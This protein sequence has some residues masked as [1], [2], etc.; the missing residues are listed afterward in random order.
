M[1]EAIDE[2]EIARYDLE[3]AQWGELRRRIEGERLGPC[4]TIDYWADQDWEA[5]DLYEHF[6][7]VIAD[8]AKP[9]YYPTFI[10]SPSDDPKGNPVEQAPPKVLRYYGALAPRHAG[11]EWVGG[12][13]VSSAPH[14]ADAGVKQTWRENTC[15]PH[16]AL[17]TLEN[18]ACYADSVL[19]YPVYTSDLAFTITQG[20]LTDGHEKVHY[21][22]ERDA[23]KVSKT[24]FKARL[25]MAPGT[26]TP[27]Y[28]LTKVKTSFGDSLRFGVRKA[29]SKVV[30]VSWPVGR[31]EATMVKLGEPVVDKTTRMQAEYL[32]VA[33]R[34]T[35]AT[36]TAIVAKA[37]Q[38]AAK[39]W[40][41]ADRAEEVERFTN[42]LT[43]TMLPATEI[44]G[45]YPYGDCFSCG[46]D[47]PGKFKQRLCKTCRSSNFTE[48]GQ[49]IAEGDIVCSTRCPIR[50]PGIVNTKTR[51]PPLKPNTGTF[52][53]PANFR[54]SPS[55]HGEL[56]PG[57]RSSAMH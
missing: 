14:W 49:M 18:L 48:V 29:V 46:R 4:L 36:R 51:H 15:R 34:Q 35:D 25:R 27:V 3:L 21:F 37:R 24:T 50:Y 30:P 2:E 47:F 19:Y 57:R 45:G 17:A 6:H 42:I 39:D 10:N 38:N 44:R 41:K 54:F 33:G 28:Q 5:A 52:A 1:D 43:S 53:S 8:Y 26:E 16:L 20:V 9:V 7:S 13:W 23:L 11:I 31:G 56:P 12:W 22:T 40:V 55:V 32:N